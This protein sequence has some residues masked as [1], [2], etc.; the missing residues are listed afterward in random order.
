MLFR[1][2]LPAT[3]ALAQMDPRQAD[4]HAI[5]PLERQQ[6]A[7][8]VA[9]R[10]GEYAAGR[11]LARSL[12]NAF[13]GEDLPLING[14]DR[15]PAWPPRIVGSITHCRS[16]CAVAIARSAD[17]LAL[18]I[19]VEP[20]EPLPE[21]IAVRVLSSSERQCIA[22]L[23][24]PLRVL[25]DRLVFSAK[26]ATYKALYPSTK[27][28]LDFPD[29]HVEL[30]AAGTFTVTGADLASFAQGEIQGRYRI[31]GEHLATA[32]VVSAACRGAVTTAAT[33]SASTAASGC[34][35][36]SES[37]QPESAGPGAVSMS[38]EQ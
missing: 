37:R 31:T 5:H 36:P 20:A 19:D 1:S 18:G 27:R 14:P 34:D 7:N 38:C 28:F 22:R 6:I 2:L 12:L 32:L 26:E 24:R 16:L 9:T 21:D 4:A 30:H 33:T 25:A 11:L 29:L 17:V 13:G 10:Q 23:P 3:V 15:A 8:A 35:A